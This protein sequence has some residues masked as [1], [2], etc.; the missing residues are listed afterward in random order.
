[1]LRVR[2][3]GSYVYGERYLRNFDKMFRSANYTGP[4]F[5]FR[6]ASSQP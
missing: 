6:A 5:G 3:G 1:L 2:R 4:Y